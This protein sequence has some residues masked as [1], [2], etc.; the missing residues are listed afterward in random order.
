M[1]I[2]LAFFAYRGPFSPMSIF[3]AFAVRENQNNASSSRFYPIIDTLRCDGV[4]RSSRQAAVIAIGTRDLSRTKSAFAWTKLRV[5]ARERQADLQPGE[6]TS[7]PSPRRAMAIGQATS[8]RRE[9]D[10][11]NHRSYIAAARQSAAPR[12]ART[13]EPH[14][15]QH[16]ETAQRQNGSITLQKIGKSGEI[17]SRIRGKILGNGQSVKQ[18]T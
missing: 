16:A 13:V 3:A 17:E 6:V 8:L 18:R 14:G 12:F 7:K 15:Q 1:D 9:R 2:F 4:L 10:R 5:V 11:S